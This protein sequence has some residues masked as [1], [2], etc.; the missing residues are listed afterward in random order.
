D[1][2]IHSSADI[3]ALTTDKRIG[4]EGWAELA[5]NN[6]IKAIDES[7]TPPHDRLLF[8]LGIR[9]VGQVTARDLARRYISL[10]G[11]QVIIDTAIARRSEL[12]PAIGESE[13]KFR[14][15]VAKEMAAVIE[16]PGIGA[17]VAD[18]LVA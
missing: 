15:R 6:L 18:A 10:D 11:L 1:G 9:H 13:E 12:E 7:R 5:A 16:T 14:L 4:R 17:E 3:Y 2:L 8:G